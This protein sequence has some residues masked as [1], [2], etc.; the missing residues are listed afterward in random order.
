MIPVMKTNVCAR[1]LCVKI[2]KYIDR[3][4]KVVIIFFSVIMVALIFGQVVNR[5]IVKLPIGWL[6]ELALYLMIYIL[7]FATE[8]GIRDKTQISVELITKKLPQSVQNILSIITTFC[9]IGFSI[10]TFI[11]SLTLIKTQYVAGMKTPGLMIPFFIPYLSIPIGFLIIALTQIITLSY[12]L[13]HKNF[14]TDKEV[15]E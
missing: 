9:V 1:R 2:I 6:E 10:M 8:M 14:H 5:N 4:E 13:I 3:A 7:M 12:K 15:K 11:S